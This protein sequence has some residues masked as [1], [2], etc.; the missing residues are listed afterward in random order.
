LKLH[1]AF[2]QIHTGTPDYFLNNLKHFCI[3]SSI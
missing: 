2:R 1:Q 3:F